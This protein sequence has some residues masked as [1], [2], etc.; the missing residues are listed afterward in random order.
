MT[1]CLKKIKLL[2][3]QNIKY[4][5]SIKIHSTLQHLILTITSVIKGEVLDKWLI[6]IMFCS[7]KGTR[8]RVLRVTIKRKKKSR[9]CW[10]KTKGSQLFHQTTSFSKK[11]HRWT[12]LSK[13]RPR[14]CRISKQTEGNTISRAIQSLKWPKLLTINSCLVKRQGW[15]ISFSKERQTGRTLRFLARICN[16]LMSRK[17]AC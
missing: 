4:R 11:F 2:L 1:L 9:S 12:E 14:L 3:F 15:R 13:F 6:S 7:R 8:K 5:S 16:L 17:G 10:W